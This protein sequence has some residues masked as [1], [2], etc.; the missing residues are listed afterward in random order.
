MRHY[1]SFIGFVGLLSFWTT[2]YSQQT[3]NTPYDDYAPA[4]RQL[5]DG[6]AELWFTSVLTSKSGR[7]RQMMVSRCTAKGFEEAKPVDDSKI[8]F[9]DPSRSSANDVLLNGVP[10]FICGGSYGVFVSNRLVDGRDYGNDIYEM[11]QSSDGSWQ[12]SRIDAVN[13]EYWDDTPSLTTDGNILFFSSDRKAPGSKRTDIFY[14]RKNASGWTPPVA[15]DAINTDASCEEAPYPGPDGY[16]Y[17][18]TNSS[19]H[20]QIWRAPMGASGIPTERG[21]PVPFAGVNSDSADATHPTFSPGG[22][23]FLFSSNR[24]ENG[25]TKDV[26]IAWVRA[27]AES[28]TLSVDVFK[29]MKKHDPRDPSETFDT[30]EA[31]RG[32]MVTLRDLTSKEDVFQTTNESGNCVFTLKH[33]SNP[34]ADLAMH[35]ALLSAKAPGLEIEIVRAGS[36]RDTFYHS[37]VSATDTL[38]YVLDSRSNFQQN[39]TVWDTSS[40]YDPGCKQN[41]PIS[42]VQFF[43]EGYWGPTTRKYRHYI[44]NC[45]SFFTDTECLITEQKC[46]SNNL[47][48]YKYTASKLDACDTCFRYSEFRAHGEDYATAVDGTLDNLKESMRSA[49]DRE[50]IDRA[51][52][53]HRKVIV[54]VTGFTDPLNYGHQCK[55]SGET[56]DFSSSRIRLYDTSL[57]PQPDMVGEGHFVTGTPIKIEGLGGN[58][59]LSKLRAYYAACLLD[60]IWQESVQTYHDLRA[61][62]VLSIRAVGRNVNIEERTNPAKR[63]IAVSIETEVDREDHPGNKP[64]PGRLAPLWKQCNE[65]GSMSSIPKPGDKRESFN[66]Q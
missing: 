4:F 38:L 61:A 15:L 58:R 40:Y 22:H 65:S 33:T 7:S 55:Y 48:N 3:P 44:P 56:I 20:Y 57:P 46:E 11:R 39:L 24:G 1:L 17:Y 54:T 29:R 60:S 51:R 21:M 14:S 5:P 43:I 19:G 28:T 31:L 16:L 63:S 34:A 35:T 50:C 25:K 27:R 30:T 2:A 32:N 62:D 59:L 64:Q 13:S 66:G 26:D 36:M 49:L 10:S 37:F 12:V 6:G 9:A 42:K 52:R 41:F 23:W 18:A 45:P 47:Y 8:N 53:K